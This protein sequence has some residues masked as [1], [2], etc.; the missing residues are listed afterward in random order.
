MFNKYFNIVDSSGAGLL[1]HTKNLS[2][3]DLRDGSNFLITHEH[4]IDSLI[5]SNNF[6]FGTEKQ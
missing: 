4:E 1:S 3:L 2:A 5:E 6:I